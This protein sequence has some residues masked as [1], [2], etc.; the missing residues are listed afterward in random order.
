MMAS[1]QATLLPFTHAG[2]SRVLT[3]AG[4]NREQFDAMESGGEGAE[5]GDAWGVEGANSHGVSDADWGTTAYVS[6]DRCLGWRCAS[7]CA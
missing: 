7:G 3:G 5:E 4:P 2:L 6:A 1:A